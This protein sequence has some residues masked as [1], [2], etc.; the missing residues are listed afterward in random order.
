MNE[1]A[2]RAAEKVEIPSPT[3]NNY[4][5][6]KLLDAYHFELETRYHNEKRWLLNRLVSGYGV[7]CGLDV[8]PGPGDT[9]VVTPG[10]ALDRW[11]REIIVPAPT[12]ALPFPASP[13]EPPEEQDPKQ[14]GRHHHHWHFQVLLCYLECEDDP[15]PVHVGE[16]DGHETCLPGTIRERY[17]VETRL[18]CAPKIT[19]ECC[20][21]E[22]VVGGKVDYGQLTR[23]VTRR[24][25]HRPGDSC[26]P[27]A[28]IRVPAGKDRHPCHPEDIDITVRPV[29]YGNDLLFELLNC[30]HEEQEQRPRGGKL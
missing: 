24:R 25:C 22:L 29:V 23:W 12:K 2:T 14:E 10:L 19:A 7:V 28:N 27:L 9:F 17:R 26:I 21:D 3:R 20:G 1:L 13:G 15:V 6:G 5:Y 18:G 30:L 8:E 4:F 11:G 16:C